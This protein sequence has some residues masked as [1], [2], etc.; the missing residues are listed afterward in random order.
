MIF[1]FLTGGFSEEHQVHNR[2]V[3]NPKEPG[4]ANR[5]SIASQSGTT[6]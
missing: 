1:S 5:Q 6:V 2:H 4:G 3:N